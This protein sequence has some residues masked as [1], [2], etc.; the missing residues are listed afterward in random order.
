MIWWLI[1]LKVI[2]LNLHKD[3]NSWILKCFK[4]I[5]H[6][7]KTGS[8]W[9]NFCASQHSP[10]PTRFPG[11][12]LLLNRWTPE[13][14]ASERPHLNL[15]QQW[16][17]PPTAGSELMRPLDLKDSRSPIMSS[18]QFST[19][20]FPINCF[21]VTCRTSKEICIFPCEVT[22]SS[23]TRHL[24]PAFLPSWLLSLSLAF[25]SL[26]MAPSNTVLA[27]DLSLRFYFLD[28]LTKTTIFFFFNHML[29]LHLASCLQ[30]VFFPVRR[31]NGDL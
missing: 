23:F 6:N 12:S 4:I 22:T 9:T 13:G 16:P 14:T 19:I 29:Y 30:S 11:F 2:H 3:T 27:R 20:S 10:A 18:R 5:S 24:V 17:G 15:L 7:F 25:G 1:Y 28:N 21:K 31:M 8:Y 26:G